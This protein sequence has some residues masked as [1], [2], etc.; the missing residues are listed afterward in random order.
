[1]CN[2]GFTNDQA[3]RDAQARAA[4]VQSA[5]PDVPAPAL[6]FFS[7]F[8][9]GELEKRVPKENVP[10]SQSS[11]TQTNRPTVSRGTKR[12]TKV[13]SSSSG[14]TSVGR[15]SQGASNRFSNET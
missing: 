10:K 8:L 13:T 3:G 14:R 12:T 2:G 11:G 1:M 5:F 6:G 4:N 9:P 7:G 15:R